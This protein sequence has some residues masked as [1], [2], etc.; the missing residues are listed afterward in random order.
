MIHNSD[1]INQRQ[2]LVNFANTFLPQN[3]DLIPKSIK[4]LLGPDLIVIKV[5]KFS[6]KANVSIKKGK[7]D[8]KL[9]QEMYSRL[10]DSVKTI[11]VARI[12]QITHRKVIS[13]RLN[14]DLEVELCVI[15]FI[16]ESK[17]KIV[18][19]RLALLLGLH[20]NRNN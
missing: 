7:I 13:C 18:K 19:T 1:L 3:L 15:D 14:I 10:F 4:V 20:R 11:F 16:L 5:D 2:A 6:W 17:A 12:E 9:S 8:K